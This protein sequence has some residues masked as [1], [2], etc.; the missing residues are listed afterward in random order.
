MGREPVGSGCLPQP[1]SATGFNVNE[2]Y[3]M[4]HAL[5]HLQDELASLKEQH[6]STLERFGIVEKQIKTEILTLQEQIADYEAVIEML[7]PEKKTAAKKA[8]ATKK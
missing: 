3:R 2:R 6:R 5:Q 4:S 8:T 7:T 1:G